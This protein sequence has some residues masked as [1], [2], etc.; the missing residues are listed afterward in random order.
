MDCC[1]PIIVEYRRV[2]WLRG[3]GSNG[4]SSQQNY[5]HLVRTVWFYSSRAYLYSGYTLVRET[6]KAY[7]G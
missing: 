5:L 6:E 1:E 4:G 2:S 7:L 3:A